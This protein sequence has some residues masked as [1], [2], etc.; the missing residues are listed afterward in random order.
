M[1][2]SAGTSRVYTADPGTTGRQN[3]DVWIKPEENFKQY[4]WYNSAWRDNTDGS[5]SQ[6][7]GILAN[8]TSTSSAAYST[9]SSAQTA[10]SNATNIANQASSAAGSAS[11]LANNAKSIADTASSIANI[12]QGVA[13]TA[14]STADGATATAND[15][16]TTAISVASQVNSLS[17]TVTDDRN[18]ANSRIDT[19]SATVATNNTA[20]NAR[21]DT[22]TSTVSD[23]KT[24]LK[25]DIATVQTTVTNNET[26]FA[27][28][29]NTVSAQSTKQRV[30]RQA[31]A[32]EG[33]GRTVGDLWYDNS[34]K[35]YYWNGSSWVDNS[36]GRFG[37]IPTIFRQSSQPSAIGRVN[38]DIWFDSSNGN[39]QYYWNGSSWVDSSDTRLT[40]IPAVYY[41]TN[42]PTGKV[43]GDIW[44]DTD[45]NNKPWYFS[46]SN[47]LDASD[48]SKATVAQVTSE[49]T[50]R[51][52]ADSALASAITAASTGSSK[53]F[54]Q[55]TNPGASG[56]ANGDIWI[57]SSNNFK[58]YV[59]YSGQ[60]NDNSTGQYTQYVG[61]YATLSQ[62]ISVTDGKATTASSDASTALSTAT[63][64]ST[65]ANSANA[66]SY[67][68]RVQGTI[69]GVTG[70]L[71]LAGAKR[72][73]Q[74]TGQVE[75]T[76]NLII[77]ANT[78][79]NGNLVVNGTIA[80]AKIADNAVSRNATASGSGNQSVT[81]TVRAGSRVQVLAYVTSG[82]SQTSKDWTSGGGAPSNPAA[83]DFSNNLT[84]TTPSGSIN[85]PVCN[86]FVSVNRDEFLG[87][88]QGQTIWRRWYDMQSFGVMGFS[89]HQNTTSSDQ[90]LTF[91]AT[92]S[93]S[94]V[95]VGI[96]VTELAK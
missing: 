94:G 50:A 43:V 48:T 70:G 44:F 80:T 66:L 81:V 40:T 60:W 2:A 89:F 47:W 7:I 34:G 55:A 23:N 77:D 57:D 71:R 22:L 3:G 95:T 93:I 14:K 45:D 21:I 54:T 68:W 65:A 84:I 85:F 12:A 19:V 29:I 17:S 82:T 4:V 16:K 61:Q 78:T 24:E 11:S 42:Q 25:A 49:T 92:S 90:S 53:V 67:D 18:N 88:F 51:V 6:Y 64:A 73:N 37:S 20:L 9:A 58:P 87:S 26:A 31:T 56:R 36:D 33:T 8:V 27:A 46:G 72:V 96:I 74:S 1:S 5:Y 69:D 10:A 30:F 86:R 75:N 13:N 79:I 32:P 39:K 76:A 41:Q 28:Q 35:P 63:A 52:N 38:G 83:F 15:A 91:S 59:W 62:S